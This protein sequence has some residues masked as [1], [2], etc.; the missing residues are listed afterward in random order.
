ME[1]CF[2]NKNRF[3]WCQLECIDCQESAM[4]TDIEH[5]IYHSVTGL[6]QVSV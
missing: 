4:F 6:L 2:L 3:P 1:L 5:S